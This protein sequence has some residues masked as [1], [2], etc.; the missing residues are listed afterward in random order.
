MVSSHGHLVTLA[1]WL[2][3]I[4]GCGV[5]V[6]AEQASRDLDGSTERLVDAAG[7]APSV[8]A[9]SASGVVRWVVPADDTQLMVRGGDATAKAM[10]LI[11]AHGAAFAVAPADVEPVGVSGPDDLGLE[12]V[13]LRQL[14]RGVPVAGAELVVHLQGGRVTAVHGTTV[15][16]ERDLGVMPSVGP[17][18]AAETVSRY[19][20]ARRGL[21][22]VH[23]VGVRLEIFDRDVFEGAGDRPARTPTRA[24]VRVGSL[25]VA[26]QVAPVAHAAIA[27]DL[28]QPLAAPA[29]RHGAI[30]GYRPQQRRRRLPRR[31]RP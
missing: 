6:H 4:A 17:D 18:R 12:H 7:G 5:I 24:R 23:I 26:R 1:V 9:D 28:E 13:R 30:H 2:A 20:V 19:L 31:R 10:D 8:R 27:A 16:V 3:S 15:A 29:G 11:A 22:G 14:H 21:S 25:P